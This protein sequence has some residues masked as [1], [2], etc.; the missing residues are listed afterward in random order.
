LGDK[1]PVK[2]ERV[3]DAMMKMSKIE[4]KELQRAYSRK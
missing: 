3:F 1:D 4:I 2:A